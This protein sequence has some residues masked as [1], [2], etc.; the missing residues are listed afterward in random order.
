VAVQAFL[1]RVDWLVEAVERGERS[2]GAERL[3]TE[4]YAH[5]LQMERRL[6]RLE[7]EMAQLAQRAEEP[8]AAKRLRR[9]APRTRA[10]RAGLDELRERLAQLNAV[11]ARG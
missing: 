4:G 2:V 9:L 7:R 3:L 1:A 11:L 8:G 10:T 6:R 5:A